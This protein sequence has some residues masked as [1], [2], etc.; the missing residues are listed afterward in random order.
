[1]EIV[2]Y[3]QWVSDSA[4][5]TLNT[6]GG[7]AVNNPTITYSSALFLSMT[8][9]REGYLFIG[10]A[11][12]PGGTVLWEVGDMFKN[13]NSLF[14]T[15]NDQVIPDGY[16]LYAVW[17]ESYKTMTYNANGTVEEPATLDNVP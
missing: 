12:E 10:W 11:K 6:T 15:E 8:P 14:N 9:I 2:L 5:L 1:M 4:T 7:N 3:A 13:N 16:T 17:D